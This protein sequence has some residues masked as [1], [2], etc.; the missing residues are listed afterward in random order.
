MERAV[1]ASFR[2]VSQ[3][4]GSSSASGSSDEFT[5]RQITTISSASSSTLPLGKALLILIKADPKSLRFWSPSTHA[6]AAS[7]SRALDSLTATLH[8]GDGAA[9]MRSVSSALLEQVANLSESSR[10][11]VWRIFRWLLTYHTTHCCAVLAETLVGANKHH[12]MYSVAALKWITEQVTNDLANEGHASPE[13]TQTAPTKPSLIPQGLLN[14]GDRLSA[15][16]KGKVEDERRIEWP[17]LLQQFLPSLFRVVKED[18]VKQGQARQPTRL[19]VGA[20]DLCLTIIHLMAQQAFAAIQREY[21]Q[22]QKQSRADRSSST[23]SSSA[24]SSSPVV[25]EIVATTAHQRAPAKAPQPA[26]GGVLIQDLG[27]E[28]E[29]DEEEEF[30]EVEEEK[31]EARGPVAQL[32]SELDLVADL[33]VELKEWYKLHRPL[34]VSGLDAL[35][36][37]TNLLQQYRDTATLH[38]QDDS[39]AQKVFAVSW[40]IYPSYLREDNPFAREKRLDPFV[41]GAKYDREGNL[42]TLVCLSL[43]LGRMSKAEI[44]AAMANAHLADFVYGELPKQLRA[45]DEANQILAVHILRSVLVLEMG[46][47][48]LGGIAS[49]LLLLLEGKDGVSAAIIGFIAEYAASHPEG[50]LEDI[51]RRLDSTDKTQRGHALAILVEVFKIDA[52][53]AQG[54]GRRSTELSKRLA[55]HLLKRLY[56]TELTLRLEASALFANLEPRDIVPALVRLVYDKDARVRSAADQA[57]LALMQGHPDVT[58]T[59]SILLDHLCERHTSDEKRESSATKLTPG[60]IGTPKALPADTLQRRE[61]QRDELAERVLRLVPKW[62][63]KLPAHVWP[64]LISVLLSHLFARPEEPVIVKFLSKVGTQLGQHL[65]DFL[66]LV[67][68]RMETQESLTEELLSS[69]ADDSAKRVRDLLFARLAPLLALKVVPFR[70]FGLADGPATDQIEEEQPLRTDDA[71][72]RTRPLIEEI[73][74]EQEKAIVEQHQQ[75]VEEE[76]E[77]ER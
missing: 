62:A 59:V 38:K 18:S 71:T 26:K 75:R 70:A 28:E 57:L 9:A 7:V 30:M 61:K 54:G 23:P 22:Q 17:R 12:K 4:V 33:L 43:L 27:G 21:H 47:E 44:K 60:V 39:T 55:D 8:T 2:E 72:V 67:L 46:S 58:G 63:E 6:A 52:K 25:R 11:R 65:L 15:N 77:E 31:K 29:E 35:Q 74:E 32:W 13:A 76:E 48:K 34:F 51:F 14:I 40:N 16:K 64:S 50:I 45:P 49:S 3:R 20:A 56:D 24:S 5:L 19:T 36:N 66:P 1:G 42:K 37:S 41:L 69:S 73:D 10:C 53:L 68:Q